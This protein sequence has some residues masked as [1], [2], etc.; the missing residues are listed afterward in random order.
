MEEDKRIVLYREDIPVKI[1]AEDL[2]HWEDKGWT[3]EK[4]SPIKKSYKKQ[5]KEEQKEWLSKED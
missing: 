5:G 4:K 1:N 2:K 3:K